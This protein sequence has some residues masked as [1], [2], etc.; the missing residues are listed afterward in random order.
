MKKLLVVLMAAAVI[1][2]AGCAD[3]SDEGTFTSDGQEISQ[4]SGVTDTSEA[5]D[6]SHASDTVHELK[7][8][9]QLLKERESEEPDADDTDAESEPG[10][11][12]LSDD[13]DSYDASDG[14]FG[15]FT[16]T[17][18]NGEKVDESIFTRK[19]LT[20]VNIWGT[21][22]SPCIEEMPDLGKIASE[23]ADR[24]FQVV[25]IVS[26]VADGGD[27]S[28][29]EDIIS[30]TGADYTHILVSQSLYDNYLYNV[31]AVPT[32]V[33]VDRNGRQVGEVY[34]GS[35]SREEWESIIDSMLQ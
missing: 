13:A 3:E 29:A 30:E 4:E 34:V 35:Q 22:C 16:S 6:T 14:V 18:V 7:S 19:D 10:S 5:P 21:F 2:V 24:S 11:G 28:D 17:T 31:Q 9:D 32:T 8:H 26:D 23:Y 27:T 20:M 25:G 1:C 15:S 33:F 12:A